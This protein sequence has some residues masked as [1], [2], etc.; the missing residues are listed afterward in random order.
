MHM[1]TPRSDLCTLAVNLCLIV[2]R[3]YIYTAAKESE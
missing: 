3:H 1:I 2:A